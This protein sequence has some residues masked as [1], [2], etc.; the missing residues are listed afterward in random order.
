MLPLFKIAA[1]ARP[2]RDR[3]RSL[4]ALLASVGALAAVLLFLPA[5]SR[6]TSGEGAFDRGPTYERLAGVWNA[7]FAATWLVSREGFLK[8][9]PI[10][11]ELLLKD[12]AEREKQV[13]DVMENLVSGFS[14]TYTSG[15]GGEGDTHE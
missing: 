11:A 2:S 1:L 8:E 4:A 6:K 15:G 5:C 13:R 10:K 9:P 14:H 7:D 3:L 12:P